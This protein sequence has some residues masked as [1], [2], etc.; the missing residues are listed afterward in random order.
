MFCK[1]CGHQMPDY[2]GRCPSCGK[3]LSPISAPS[4]TVQPVI[5]SNSSSVRKFAE[6]ITRIAIEKTAG[7]PHLHIARVSV[8]IALFA[9]TL[10]FISVSCTYNGESEEY[11]FSGIRLCIAE[12]DSDSDSE[13]MR[14]PVPKPNLFLL[15]AFA[16]GIV[17]AF[18]LFKRNAKVAARISC[19]SVIALLLFRV[20]LFGYYDELSSDDVVESKFGF[21]LCVVMMLMTAVASFLEHKQ[22][23]SSPIC[24]GESRGS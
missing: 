2:V 21:F 14:Y 20:T 11:S 13:S 10:P 5:S 24:V 23:G 7:C 15:I 6:R 16:G 12:K 8:L 9:F 22:N 19:I 4:S 17:T 1:Y 18:F 3:I